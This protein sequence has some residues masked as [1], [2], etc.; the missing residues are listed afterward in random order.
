[1]SD[2]ISDGYAYNNGASLTGKSP[3]RQMEKTSVDPV[4][5]VEEE[6]DALKDGLE[7]ADWRPSGEE[8]VR[9]TIGRLQAIRDALGKG[10]K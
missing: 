8:A 6:I 1:M 10:M 2:G 4:R 7:F 3:R 9:R 5:E